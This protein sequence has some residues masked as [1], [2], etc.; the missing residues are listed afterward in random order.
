MRLVH[1]Y[2]ILA[3]L[4]ITTLWLLNSILR[5]TVRRS[6]IEDSDIAQLNKRQ[7]ADQLR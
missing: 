5:L 3:V 7:L 2:V 6:F 4:V 1:R